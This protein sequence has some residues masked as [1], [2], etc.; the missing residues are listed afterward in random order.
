MTKNK[1]FFFWGIASFVIMTVSILIIFTETTIS[2]KFTWTMA[3]LAFMFSLITFIYNYYTK[4]KAIISK[5]FVYYE[6]SQLYIEN[7]SN[8]PIRDLIIFNYVNKDIV[9]LI[10]NHN[11]EVN[12]VDEYF[13]EAVKS[14]D[15]SIEREYAV[16]RIKELFTGKYTTGSTN[17]IKDPDNTHLMGYTFVDFF[18]N[19]WL[20]LPY[21]NF[22]L[23]NHNYYDKIKADYM[24]KYNAEIIMKTPKLKRIK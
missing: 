13:L 15:P 19:N 21:L 10:V 5:V 4:V 3:F 11:N 12:M 23:I 20:K 24:K 1:L 16:V 2:N 22:K 6:D 7:R 8:Y 9:P 18:G 17:F 14:I